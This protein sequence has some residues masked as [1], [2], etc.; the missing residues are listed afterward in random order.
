MGLNAGIASTRPMTMRSRRVISTSRTCAAYSR[1]DRRCGDG[2]TTE[3]VDSAS[4]IAAMAAAPEVRRGPTSPRST[5]SYTKPQSAHVS[6]RAMVPG[7]GPG[8][9]GRRCCSRR[10]RRVPMPSRGQSIGE[11]GIAG[12]PAVAWRGR[13]RWRAPSPSRPSPRSRGWDRPGPRAAGRTWPPDASPSACSGGHPV[14]GRGAHQLCREVRA[15]E[16]LAR[17]TPSLS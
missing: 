8:R 14:R 11:P 2:R 7:D 17:V 1:L 3:R 4:R 9:S 5:S 10:R 15:D 16:G 6:T 12:A 13:R